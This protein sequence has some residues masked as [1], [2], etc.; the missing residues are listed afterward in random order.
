VTKTPARVLVAYERG[1]VEEGYDFFLAEDEEGY[2]IQRRRGIGPPHAATGVFSATDTLGQRVAKLK[3]A[4]LPLVSIPRG[5]QEL[6]DAR[7]ARERREGD[8]KRKRGNRCA[9][10][11]CQ[12]RAPAEDDP[13]CSVE[14]ARSHHGVVYDAD[15]RSRTN[16]VAPPTDAQRRGIDNLIARTTR[17]KAKV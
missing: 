15:A 6:A 4:G 14:C 13:F 9:R 3:A 11:G 10:R 16:R 5:A 17:P 8:P 7:A 2:V 1:L 12:N